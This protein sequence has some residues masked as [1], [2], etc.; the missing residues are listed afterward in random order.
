M[1]FVHLETQSFNIPNAING[2]VNPQHNL[3][4]M[5]NAGYRLY[6]EPQPPA[7]GYERGAVT[8][9]Q[10]PERPEYAL[11]QY[12]DTLIQ[13]RLDAEAAAAAA[14]AAQIAASQAAAA[15]A[16]AHVSS[17]GNAYLLL[18]DTVAGR[19]TH[20]KLSS[21]EMVPVMKAL[22]ISDNATYA[23][24]VAAFTSLAFELIRSNVLWW[25]DV[26]WS[27]DPAIMAA[28]QAIYDGLM[29]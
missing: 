27:D 2:T 8:W 24:A 26:V 11:P 12:V 22:E 21:A 5:L 20:E 6:D 1:T 18:C 9:I 4:V 10:D 19:T 17:Y 7:D 28:G 14:R 13:D 15:A 16:A 23:K 3:G 29:A 25:D